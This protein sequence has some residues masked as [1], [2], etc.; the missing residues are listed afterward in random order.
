MQLQAAGSD[1]P[2]QARA[3][4]LV[5]AAGPWVETVLKNAGSITTNHLR[6]IKGSHIITHKIW[7]GDHAYLLQN[8]D[9]RVIFAIPYERDFC[10]IGT[11]DIAFAGKAEDVQ[12]TREEQDYLLTA[13]NRYFEATLSLDDIVQSYSGVRPLYDDSSANPSA[14]TRDYVFNIDAPHGLAPILSIFGG[15]ITT[16]R[17]L[18]EHAL[19]RL[20]PFF[21]KMGPL[22]TQTAT[23]PGGD[24]PDADFDRMLAGLRRAY[25][26]LPEVVSLE[27]ARRYGTRATDLLKDATQLDDL[28]RFFGGTLY[29]REARFLMAEEWARSADDILLRR[30]KH[31]LH[32]TQAEQESFAQ[33]FAAQ[34]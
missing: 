10:L 26:F 25:P 30:T 32:L 17:K 4:V 2:L 23:L 16:Y 34:S 11:T 7:D 28:G 3:K 19:D 29:E 13:V 21:P 15:K 1:K 14:V 22:W 5:N 24:M 27:Y 6:L 9:G 18:A 20:K 12:I 33:G 31:S 8:A